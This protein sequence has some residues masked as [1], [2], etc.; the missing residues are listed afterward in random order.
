M[1]ALLERKIHRILLFAFLCGNL[2][3]FFFV[4]EKLCGWINSKI[5][6]S[7]FYPWYAGRPA[8]VFPVHTFPARFLGGRKCYWSPA[9]LS[10]V[11]AKTK[12]FKKFW[13]FATLKKISDRRVAQPVTFLKILI[14]I[15]GNADKSE[16]QTPW[17]CQLLFS[18]RI[19]T[20][21]TQSSVIRAVE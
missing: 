8:H 13:F 6:H 3:D 21:S 18:R 2:N 14:R 20:H 9:D 17:H 5:S 19:F 15:L 7:C 16:W 1:T 12:N 11:P 10:D 4:D